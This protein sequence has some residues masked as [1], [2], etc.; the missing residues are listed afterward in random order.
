MGFI[1]GQFFKKTKKDILR[2]SIAVIV[3]IL[4]SFFL[5]ILFKPNVL[6]TVHLIESKISQGK[7][8]SK[9]GEQGYKFL[10][11][12]INNGIK[13]PLQMIVLS[14]IPIPY[15]YFAPVALTAILT[16]FVLYLPTTSILGAKMSFLE[17]ILGVLPHGIVEFGGYVLLLGALYPINTWI[18]HKVFRRKDEVEIFPLLLQGLIGFCCAFLI[19]VIAAAIEAFFTPLLN[20]S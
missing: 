18:C 9:G 20:F 3:L 17:V 2:F 12:I 5:C 8:V 10:Q 7:T 13:I 11:Y 1:I 19:F 14:L 16:G 15:L 4:V 6:G